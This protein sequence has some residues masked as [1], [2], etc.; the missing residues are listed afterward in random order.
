MNLPIGHW[1]DVPSRQQFFDSGIH[2]RCMFVSTV[3]VRK[4]TFFRKTGRKGEMVAVLYYRLACQPGVAR[5]FALRAELRRFAPLA[6]SAQLS[7]FAI[8]QASD[9]LSERLLF[10]CSSGIAR[11]FAQKAIRSIKR[12]D[13]ERFYPTDPR[14]TDRPKHE[15]CD[16]TVRV[17]KKLTFSKYSQLSI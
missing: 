3:M 2:E 5:A 1:P 6:G 15:T 4:R 13:F 9:E 12:V 10:H 17:Y 14:N 16:K 11:A 8:T 7:R